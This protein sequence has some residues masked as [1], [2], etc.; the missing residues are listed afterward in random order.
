MIKDKTNKQ[1]QPLK[2]SVSNPTVSTTTTGIE[3]VCDI[4]LCFGRY[5]SRGAAVEQVTLSL[6]SK[7]QVA[8]TPTSLVS[9]V[10]IL[11]Q[12]HFELFSLVLALEVTEPVPE[13]VTQMAV[14]LK[15]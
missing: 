5:G 14:E 7:K 15:E 10:Q 6:L 11:V 13:S 2:L 9:L 3:R 1:T 4:C 12:S 8:H